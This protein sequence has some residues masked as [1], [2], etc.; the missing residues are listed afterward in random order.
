MRLIFLLFCKRFLA[1]E[2]LVIN[3]DFTIDLNGFLID[4][5]MRFHYWMNIRQLE[6]V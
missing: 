3:E 1:A 5:V 2:N 4:S 6:A